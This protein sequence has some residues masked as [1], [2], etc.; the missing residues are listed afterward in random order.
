MVPMPAAAAKV[1]AKAAAP[2]AAGGQDAAASAGT[3][4]GSGG[5]MQSAEEE[6]EQLAIE[7]AKDAVAVRQTALAVGPPV[8][9]GPT[10]RAGKDGPGVDPA[11]NAGEPLLVAADAG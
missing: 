9:Y 10:R 1:A 5:G 3:P 6:A 2:K 4:D 8:S 7:D 11:V